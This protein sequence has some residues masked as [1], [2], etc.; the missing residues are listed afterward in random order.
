MKCQFYGE[1]RKKQFY[2]AKVFINQLKLLS[3]DNTKELN[4][5]V[6]YLL[7]TWNLEVNHCNMMP[8][9]GT[10]YHMIISKTYIGIIFIFL[11]LCS[12]HSP[13]AF[14]RIF[15][16]HIMLFVYHWVVKLK[17]NKLNSRYVNIRNKQFSYAALSV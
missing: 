10:C 11:W 2:H 13:I 5:L 4:I 1:L 7:Q 17:Y 9:C 16:L 15:I 3:V 8:N 6:K 14:Y 12:V